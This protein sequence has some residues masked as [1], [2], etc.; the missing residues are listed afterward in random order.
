MIEYEFDKY[1]D[2]E[3]CKK[4]LRV[5]HDEDDDD[6]KDKAEMALSAVSS[7]LNRDI[8]P[9]D[10]EIPEGDEYSISLKKS[11]RGAV[12]LLMTDLYENRVISFDQSANKNP[13]FA[14]LLDPW[15]NYAVRAV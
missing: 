14:L 3:K 11:I 4:Q 5:Y 15:M 9:T 1:F 12:M 2:L 8:Y 10:A 6:I 7:Y 13:V